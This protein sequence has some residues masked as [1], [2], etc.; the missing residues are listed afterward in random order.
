MAVFPPPEGAEITIGK[1]LFL[2]LLIHAGPQD[3]GFKQFSYILFT[4][5]LLFLG[6]LNWAWAAESMAIGTLKGEHET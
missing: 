6:Y 5:Y 4:V 1:Y 2:L 3:T